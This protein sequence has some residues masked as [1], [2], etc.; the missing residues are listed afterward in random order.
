[1]MGLLGQV[2]PTVSDPCDTVSVLVS[3]LSFYCCAFAAETFTQ[4]LH[5]HKL[6]HGTNPRP[7]LRRDRSSKSS[8][9]GF[10]E[11]PSRPRAVLHL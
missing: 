8:R 5:E 2:L 7:S 9:I 10:Q 3:A 11:L 4:Y 1:M 6:A